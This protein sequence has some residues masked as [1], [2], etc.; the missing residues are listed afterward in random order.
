[1]ASVE[2]DIAFTALLHRFPDLALSPTADLHW[3]TTLIRGLLELPV[4][5][6]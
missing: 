3:P 6:R 2:A 5:L 1:M 4:R